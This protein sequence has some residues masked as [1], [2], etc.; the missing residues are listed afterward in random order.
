MP[1]FRPALRFILCAALL[2][3]LIASP[4]ELDKR[5]SIALDALVAG[6]RKEG[7]LMFYSAFPN[8][9]NEM[10]LRKFM[11]AYPFVK[12]E[13]VRAGGPVIA[14]RFY[15]EKATKVER[16]DVMQSGAIEAY[17]DWKKK[18]YISRVDNLPEWKSTVELA[19][20]PGGYYVAIAYVQH[21]LAWNRKVHKDS[22][23]PDDLW[24]FTKPQWAGKTASG[25]PV[26][27]GFALNWFSFASELRAAD[28]RGKTG[29]SGLGMKWLE[30]MNKNGHLLAGQLGN[31]TDALVSGRRSVAIHHWD[32]EI[33]EANKKGADLGWKYA[34]QGPMAQQIL[35]AINEAAPNPYT[36]RLFVNWLLTKEGQTLIMKEATMS[37]SRADM[38]TSDFLRGRKEIAECW[39]LD[40]EKIT[41]EETRQ[42]LDAMGNVFGAAS[43]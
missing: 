26:N 30:A 41:P 14:Q 12:A 39:V 1:T 21:V 9:T 5:A 6:A 33:A 25:H 35:G 10:L 32:T 43:K 27:A 42:F 36:A 20:G 15:T 28:P 31:L 18:G 38:K 37:T 4:H 7:K 23:I 2:Q 24:E 3:P 13:V 17:P 19:R 8:F 40:I 34:K 29:A 11:E 16:M 22:D